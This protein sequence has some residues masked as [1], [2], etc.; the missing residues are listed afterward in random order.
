MVRAVSDGAALVDGLAERVEARLAAVRATIAAAGVAPSSVTIVAVTK[1][2]G[3]EAPLAA[4][5][6]GLLDVG[7]NY[8]DELV[9]KAQGAVTAGAEGLRWHFLGA[10]QTNK[11]N[12]LAPIVQAW[13]TLDSVHRVAALARRAA[14][15]TVFV[16]VDLTGTPGRGGCAPRETPTVVRAAREAGLH[17]R[18]LMGVGPDPALHGEAASALAFAALVGLAR[19]EGLTELSAGMSD[20]FVAALAA[21]S[22]LLRLGSVLFGPRPGSLTVT[23][24]A[25]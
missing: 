4:A 23:G 16:Q 3:V 6:V 9:T 14:G 18:G 5:R 11:I 7:E 8:A 19:S 24:E 10:V 12:R 25:L 21:G 20:D 1:G 22:R 2:F 17:V 13:H 15:A